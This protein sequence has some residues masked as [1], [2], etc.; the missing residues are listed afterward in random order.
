MEKRNE[1]IDFL[2]GVAIFLVVYGHIIQYCIKNKGDFFLNLVF[3]IIYSFHMPLFMIISGYLFY[4]T[5][6]NNKQIKQLIYKKFKQLI[7][8][9]IS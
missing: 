1:K 2:K 8:P 7:V 3:K 6:Q 9:A 5:L 4:N